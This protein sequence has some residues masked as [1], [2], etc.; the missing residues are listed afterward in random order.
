MLEESGTVVALGKGVLWV[1]TQARS[2]CSQCS[3]S[4]CT[5]SVV[6]KLF[7][8][9]P[10]RLEL[11]NSLNAE[12]GQQVVIGIPDDLLVRASVWAYL[13]PV[14]IML[15]AAAMAGVAGLGEGAQSLLA[16]LGLAAGFVLAA[17]TTR[18]VAM[19]ARLKPK[20]L[21][22]ALA[23]KTMLDRPAITKP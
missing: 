17:Y 11:E 7:G 22:M 4:S 1:E 18:C 16:L 15:L 21:R 6:S 8:V 10:N 12:L 20:L 2:S 3:S 19:Q 9:K 5:T 23:D 14:L 13:V